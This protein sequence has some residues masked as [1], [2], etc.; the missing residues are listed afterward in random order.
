MGNFRLFQQA[1]CKVMVKY[2]NYNLLEHEW[3]R[4]GTRK[5]EAQIDERNKNKILLVLIQK[6]VY[7]F[8]VLLVWSSLIIFLC[9]WFPVMWLLYFFRRN[10]NQRAIM[11]RLILHPLK[12][13]L[14][15]RKMYSGIVTILWTG[16]NI[17]NTMALSPF[18]MSLPPRIWK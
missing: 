14:K 18:Q 7:S 15:K 4:K 12:L 13:F 8:L 10:S 11:L 16:R 5:L 17:T 3:I 2:T 9:I 6:R 1:R